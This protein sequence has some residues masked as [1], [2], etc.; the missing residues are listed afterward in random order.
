MKTQKSILAVDE[1]KGFFTL[2][3]RGLRVSVAESDVYTDVALALELA[4]TGSHH[5]MS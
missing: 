2:S 4:A 5:H 1:A 3:I